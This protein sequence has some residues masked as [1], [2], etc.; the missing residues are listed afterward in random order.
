M[1]TSRLLWAPARLQPLDIEM[2]AREPENAII[3]LVS[4]HSYWRTME[5]D[6]SEACV[7]RHY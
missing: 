4:A 5:S 6:D 3:S 7:T 2:V 1:E